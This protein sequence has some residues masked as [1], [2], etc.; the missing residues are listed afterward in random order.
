[1]QKEGFKT[2]FYYGGSPKWNKLYNYVPQMGYQ[3]FLAE[4]VFEKVEKQKYG[5]HDLDI[6]LELDKR[7][8]ASNG[9]TFDF[10]M[11]L[12]NH[13]PYQI[14]QSFIDHNIYMPEALRKILIDD[15]EHFKLR[16]NAFRYAD[17]ALGEYMK[18]AA[19]SPYFQ[20]TVYLITADHSFT[21]TVGFPASDTWDTENIPFLIYAPGLLRP[22]LKG[23]TIEN[24]T[25]HL[26][27]LPTV[28]SMVSDDTSKELVTWGKVMVDESTT[29][30]SGIKQVFSCLEGHCGVDGQ[31]YELG[32]ERQFNKEANTPE[33]EKVKALIDQATNDYYSSGMHFLYEFKN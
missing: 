19:E 8:K 4:N 16:L 12:S 13:P 3:E 21:S 27:I 9:P 5:L 30:D 31:L 6:F 29:K 24:Y 32:A 10:L 14:P 2:S 22:E 28:V 26:D 11:T 17:Y 25:T 18:K 33:N 23:K 1:M 7:L 15:P 20:D